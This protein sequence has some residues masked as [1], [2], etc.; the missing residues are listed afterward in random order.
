MQP[1][2]PLH[3]WRACLSDKKCVLVDSRGRLRQR[4]CRFAHACTA[5]VNELCASASRLHAPSHRTA[6]TCGI[7][8]SARAAFCGRARVVA[9]GAIGRVLREFG[10]RCHV[11][12]PHGQRGMGCAILAH[13]CGRRR[14]RHLRHRRPR[15]RQRRLQGRVGQHR[16]RCAAGLSQG[17]WSVGYSRGTT[18]DTEGTEGS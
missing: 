9:F 3:V 15:R 5:C 18:G 11:D 10:C 16:R 8:S 6:G 17:G 12:V 7:N 13:V 1:P 14:R 4:V 2:M